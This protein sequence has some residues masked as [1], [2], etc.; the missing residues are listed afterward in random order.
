MAQRVKTVEYAFDTRLTNLATNTTLGT[1]TRHDFTAVAIALPETTSRT[2]RSVKIVLSWRD[3][4]TTVTNY[5]SWRIGIKLGAVAFTDVDYAP[6]AQ[7][8]A[9]DHECSFINSD[10]T[11]YF[12]TNYT[13]SSMNAQVGIA[14]ATA[15][16]QNINNITAKLIIT[17]EYDDAGLTSEVKTVRLPIQ[18]RHALLTNAQQEIG[19]TGG[20]NNASA[21]QIPILTG[22]SGILTEASVSIQQAWIEVWSND[23]GAATTDFNAFYQIDS[24]GEVTRATLE[25]AL[26]NG[27][28][29]YDIFIYDTSTYSTTSAHAFKARSSTTSRFDSLGA[30]LHVTYTYDP[31]TT[32]S[33]LNSVILALGP[34]LH[35][36]RLMGTTAGDG[37]VYSCDYWVEEPGT[38]TT[39]QS[40]ALMFVQSAGGGTFR[41]LAG[42]QAERSYTMTSLVN[43]GGNV[44]VHRCDHGTSPWALARGFNNLDFKIYTTAADVA[45]F[46]GGIVYLNYTSSVATDGV[47]VHN[48]STFWSLSD[49]PTS[50]AASTSREITTTNQHTPNIPETNYFLNGVVYQVFNRHS[51]ALNPQSLFAE[52]LSGEWNADGWLQVGS[53]WFANDGELNTTVFWMPA[54]DLFN[55]TNQFSGKMNIETARKYRLQTQT[56]ALQWLS[57]VW[58]TYHGITFAC[59]GTV[60]GSSGGTVDVAALDTTDYLK[61]GTSSRTGDGSYSITVYDNT[62]SYFVEARESAS[63][64]GRSDNGTPA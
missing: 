8:N 57:G 38:I 56:A 41:C 26:N 58:V 10:V 15:A 43:S 48:K 21:N 14:V 31:S 52:A 49:F 3:A 1:A 37:Q 50:G 64:L 59:A 63:L 55:L 27:V 20:T 28:F 24:A 61:W 60:G 6:T 17:Y 2:F 18:S 39:L 33:V 51:T 9:G 45:T 46:C 13:G 32:T 25:Q 7:A 34:S 44:I 11:A 47:N 19:T 36:T 53:A 29:Y 62:R 30:V 23:A 5:T 12:V 4:S 16:A 54:L 42:G 40:G 35:P 22:G